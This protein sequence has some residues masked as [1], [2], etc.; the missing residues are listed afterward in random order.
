MLSLVDMVIGELARQACLDEDS[1]HWAIIATREAVANA[2]K[3]AHRGEEGKRVR[4]EF[5]VRTAVTPP[6][7][8]IL[9]RDEGE[10]F[11]PAA[12]ADPLHEDNLCKPSGRGLLIMRSMVDDFVIRRADGGGMEA[13]IT[14]RA[15]AVEGS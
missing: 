11:D 1:L 12:V 15:K 14:M 5:S 10:G 7:L 9:V 13:V 2:M 4:M 6:E 8:V 3:H